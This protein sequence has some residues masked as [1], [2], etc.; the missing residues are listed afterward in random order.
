[1]SGARD[2]WRPDRGTGDGRSGDEI[3]SARDPDAPAGP[4]ARAGGALAAAGGRL[5]DRAGSGRLVTAVAVVVVLV[6]AGGAVWLAQTTR[7]P[8]L[9]CTAHAGAVCEAAYGIWVDADPDRAVT[10]PSGWSARTARYQGESYVTTAAASRV[11]PPPGGRDDC[12]QRAAWA[13]T[14]D[15]VP[16]D[17][18]PVRLTV[19]ARRGIPVTVLGYRVQLD[20]AR[21]APTQG[22]LLTCSGVIDADNLAEYNAPPWQRRP[23]LYQAR[24]LPFSAAAPVDLDRRTSELIPPGPN[25]GRPVPPVHVPARTTAPLLVAATTDGCACRWRLEV[26]LL[27]AGE[28]RVVTAGPDGVRPGPAAANRGQPSFETTSSAFL[29][30]YAFVDG[31]WRAAGGLTPSG[32]TQPV[33]PLLPVDAVTRALGS[34][35]ADP[36]SQV[37][38]NESVQRSYPDVSYTGLT[39]QVSCQ[40][41]A[42]PTSW[43]LGTLTVETTQVDDATTARAV[44]D[45]RRFAPAG[46][47]SIFGCSQGPPTT[48]SAPVEIQGVGDAAVRSAGQLLV[49]AAD[50]VVR[51]EL[52][53]PPTPAPTPPP[54]IVTPVP[55]DEAVLIQLARAVLAG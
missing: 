19:S 24:T 8:G 47:P 55:G 45:Q 7:N 34:S 4:L 46:T 42:S 30:P 9:P 27:V 33:C 44:F 48:A 29:T 1:M 49:L 12:A 31:A 16:A 53:V 6:M 35:T 32:S 13:G 21:P 5:L 52:C 10:S 15:S 51:V 25:D 28:Q 18:S 40:W 38:E 41:Q 22:I 2:S 54:T 11:P 37:D 17:L 23:A 26:T 36:P 43:E 20:E 50:R 39:R 3:G 14:I